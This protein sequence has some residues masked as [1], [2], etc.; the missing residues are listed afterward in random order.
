MAP[1]TGGRLRV[2]TGPMG[3]WYE[4]AGV[5]GQ[6]RRL[7]DLDREIGRLPFPRHLVPYLDHEALV[8]LTDEVQQEILAR[9]LYE[10]ML[11]TV[12]LE[13]KVV[14]RGVALISH[15]ELD[16]EVPLRTRLDA[17]KIYC[18]EGYHALYSL[19]VVAQIAEATGIPVPRHSFAPR[20]ERLART[21]HRYL[22][23]DPGLAQLLQVVAFETSVTAMLS[24]IP[25]DPSTYTVVREVVADH[26]RDEAHHHA[27]FARFFRELWAGLSPALRLAAA[28]SMPHLVNDCI[29]PDLDPV[30]QSLIQAGLA[31]DLA[32]DV[33]ADAYSEEAM[34]RMVWSNG[35]YTLRLC[36]SVGA[37]DLP[38]A[39]EELAALGLADAAGQSPG[40]VLPGGSLPPPDLGHRSDEGLE[41]GG[42]T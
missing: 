35:R 42:G 31:K 7:L 21:S 24:D 2:M 33:V 11:Y 8:D 15:G 26:A 17:A 19:D 22:P 4:H 40:T 18:D 32:D 10:Y 27:F 29:R 9:H 41:S 39:R 23:D 5:R 34:R 3:Q 37:F 28:R 13:T 12:D 1:A 30:R 16:F 6:P 20:L 14:N 36:E 25:R 38:G